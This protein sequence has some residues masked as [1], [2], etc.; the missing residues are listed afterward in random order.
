MSPESTLVGVPWNSRMRDTRGLEV[1][2]AIPTAIDGS[3]G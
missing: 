2:D 3:L 1:P